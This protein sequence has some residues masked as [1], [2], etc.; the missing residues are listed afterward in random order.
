[1]LLGSCGLLELSCR[2]SL[3]REKDC[4]QSGREAEREGSEREGEGERGGGGRKRECKRVGKGGRDGGTKR[5]EGE[6]WWNRG[7]GG[8]QKRERAEVWKVG[9]K[10]RQT[11]GSQTDRWRT[12][13]RQLNWKAGKEVG[14]RNGYGEIESE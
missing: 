6:G 1:M 9:Q 5:R 10:A 13:G 12:K 7:R 4:L 11:D 8:G 14:K 2:P 3:R